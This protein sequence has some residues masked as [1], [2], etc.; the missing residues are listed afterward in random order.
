MSYS[1]TETAALVQ[2][3]AV[4]AGLTLGLAEEIAEACLWLFQHGAPGANAVADALAGLALDTG[5]DPF[6]RAAVD[7][8]AR[9]DMALG[10][11][12][13]SGEAKVSLKRVDVPLLAM[14]LAALR[15]AQ[16]EL[17][18]SVYDASHRSLD[19]ATAPIG[20][21]DLSIQFEARTATPNPPALGRCRFDD[22]VYARLDA[23]ARNTLTPAS[24]TSRRSGAGAGLT[25]SD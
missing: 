20:P 4:G 18:A 11:A 15:A 3:A 16:L 14:G 17:S 5:H 8:P 6:T 7:V 13:A 22:A 24:E 25:D 19:V 10:L 2:R 23:L 21:A 12:L 1:Q 9:L